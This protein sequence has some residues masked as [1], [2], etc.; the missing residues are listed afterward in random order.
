MTAES[1]DTYNFTYHKCRNISSPED[2]A[3]GRRVFAGCAPSS[4]ILPFE[5]DENVR[6]YLV[7]APGKQKK[8]PTLVHQAIRKTLK[9]SPEHFGVLNSGTVIVAR[10]AEVDDKKRVMTLRGAS[11]INGSQTQGELQRFFD[12]QSDDEKA[13]PSIKF[14]IVVTD[15]DNLIAEISIARNFQNDVKAIS[16]AGRRGQLDA[17][18]AEI[19]KRIPGAKLRKAETD[20]TA[21][22]EGFLDTEKIIQATFA[23]LPQTTKT[24]DGM[25]IDLGSKVFAYSQK[26]RCLKLFQRLADDGNSTMYKAFVG[27]AP[28]AWEL[29]G[30]WKAHQGFAGTGIRSIERDGGKIIDVPDGIIFPILA[31]HSVFVRK[32][33]AQWVLDKPKELSDDKLI[34]AAKS[35]YMDIADHN[36]QSMGKSKACYSNLLQITSIYAELLK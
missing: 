33:K 24:P 23:L 7:D 29:Y 12:H 20:S 3:A 31:A 13:D 21:P 30:A 14:E 18:E 34:A 1:S 10:G 6:E 17:L 27:I 4:S 25:E 2:E 11:I 28:L 32:S 22:A 19:A 15:D 35:A 9:E 26:T 36:P 5:D 16:I 8:S